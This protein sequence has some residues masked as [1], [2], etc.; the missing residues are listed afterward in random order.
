MICGGFVGWHLA[1]T[2]DVLPMGW[3]IVGAFVLTVP[4]AFDFVAH[5][6]IARYRSS[7]FRRFCTG[8]SFGFVVGATVASALHGQIWPLMG[9][10]AYLMMMQVAIAAIFKA[11]GH[12][13]AYVE[14]YATATHN[15]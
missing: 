4:A 7:T 8:I 13:D 15:G 3:Q 10:L 6:L 12:L 5:E 1:Q 11:T 2:C 9:L 14:R